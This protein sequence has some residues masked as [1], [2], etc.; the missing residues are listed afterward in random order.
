MARGGFAVQEA[1]GSHFAEPRECA[2]RRRPPE[3]AE[4]AGILSGGARR[5]LEMRR[6]LNPRRRALRWPHPT[7]F[8]QEFLGRRRDRP[9]PCFSMRQ[10]A[11]GHMEMSAMPKV[12]TQI[13]THI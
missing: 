9:D 7:C 3:G 8:A 5:A 2:R 4:P 13:T 6:G 1:Q 12:A 10:A 11:T